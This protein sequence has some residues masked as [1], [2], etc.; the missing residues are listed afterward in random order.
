MSSIFD[1]V[2]IFFPGPTSMADIVLLTWAEASSR[3]LSQSR[4][5]ASERGSLARRIRR[6][7]EDELWIEFWG[8]VEGGESGEAGDRVLSDIADGFDRV[9]VAGR[10][11]GVFG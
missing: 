1:S 5:A 8:G 7:H 3:R 11:G 4:N 10:K 2:I 9:G 6:G